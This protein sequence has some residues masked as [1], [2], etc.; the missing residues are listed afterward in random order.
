VV[1]VVA[2]ELP[3]PGWVVA[4]VDDVV[5]VFAWPPGVDDAGGLAG[6]CGC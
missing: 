6:D 3:E 2:D 4:E 1:D 5:A